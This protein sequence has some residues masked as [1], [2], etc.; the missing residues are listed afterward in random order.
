MGGILK[1]RQVQAGVIGMGGNLA[2]PPDA[3]TKG[4]QA[5]F[6]R[7]Y[8]VAEPEVL[9]R[10]VLEQMAYW[11]A[12]LAQQGFAALCHEWRV[13]AHPL[14]TPLVVK[15]GTTYEQGLF[16]GLAPDGRLLLETKDGIKMI[17]TGDILLASQGAD[18][19]AG[20]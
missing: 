8:G 12:F 20:H 16:A 7:Q 13:R 6:L 2:S 1:E 15:G 14:G 18:S 9:A 4:R 17:A 19:A 3:Q 11:C 10:N 5:A